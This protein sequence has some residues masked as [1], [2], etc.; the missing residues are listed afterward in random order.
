MFLTKKHISRRT[1]LRSSAGVTLTLPFL[2]A[3]VPAQTP[4]AK[5]AATPLQ[6]FGFIYVPHGSIM[7][8]WTPAQDG[9]NFEYSP[10]LKP[11]EPLRDRINV[12]SGLSNTGEN[13]HSPSTAMWLSGTFPAK[14]SV[15]RLNT[16]I[17]QI[18]AA[19]VGQSTTFPSI[20][21][22]TEDHSSHLGSC[23]G[24][25]LC[26]YMSTISWRTATQPLP[27]EINPRVVFERMF[28]GDSAS[29]E[30][31]LAHLEQ[32]NSILD[33]VR[34]SVK[35][36][37]R[38]LGAK[39]RAK[40]GEYVD[41]VRE[42]ERRIQQAEK[43]RTETLIET[44]P[45]PIGVPESWEEHVKLMFDL[46]ALAYQGNLTRVTSFMMARELSTLTYPQI[47]VADG[48]HPVSHNNN[49]PEQV[50]KKA[51]IDSYHLSLFGDFLEKL[52][53]I[54]D[55]DGNLLDHSMFLYGSGMSNGN[56]H[57][58]D[59]LPILLAGGAA[60]RLKGGRHIKMDSYTPLSNLMISVLDIAGVP[61]DKFGESWGR[62]EL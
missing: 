21:L 46:M 60:G 13:G 4:I 42:I 25:F 59:N 6:R 24:D 19:R 29:A 58:H 8:D 1:F 17:D 3:M 28:G 62:V 22:A 9:V 14:G 10:I 39:D 40:L 11:I 53:S 43:Q 45:V 33:A 20:E 38:G 48:H 37:Q 61:T 51:K 56:Q 36:L 54:P 23:A 31:R 52:Q 57:T 44:P 5:T 34:E 49:V 35:D 27:M 30:E 16:T 7:K 12:I 32:N 15:I 55:G 26:S 50:A 47:G 41:N 2:D 18:I